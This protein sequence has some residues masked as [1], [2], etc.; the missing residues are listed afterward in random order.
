ML[1]KSS[2]GCLSYFKEPPLGAW[3]DDEFLVMAY[4][5]GVA[6]RLDIQ[7]KDAGDGVTWD[8]LQRLKSECGFGEFDATEFYPRD[9]DVLNTGNHRHLYVFLHHLPLIRRP[10]AKV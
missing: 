3:E 5:D 4:A 2:N 6:I 1:S 7:R 9:A 10:Q 8:T